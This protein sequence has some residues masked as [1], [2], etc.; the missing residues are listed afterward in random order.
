MTLCTG[1]EEAEAR[2]LLP[3]L[4]KIGRIAKIEGIQLRSML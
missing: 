3:L 1:V 4:I 2:V